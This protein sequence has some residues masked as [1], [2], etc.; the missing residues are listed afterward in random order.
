MSAQNLTKQDGKWLSVS[1]VQSAR[2]TELRSEN[3]DDARIK[4]DVLQ[5]NLAKLDATYSGFFSTSG[6][7]P[8]FVKPPISKAF[9]TNQGNSDL[10]AFSTSWFR[11]CEAPPKPAFTVRALRARTVNAKGARSKVSKV[12][13]QSQVYA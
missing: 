4:A 8:S 11:R 3:P 12:Y 7:S 1:G 10:A 6:G 5:G 13:G 9:S 2:T